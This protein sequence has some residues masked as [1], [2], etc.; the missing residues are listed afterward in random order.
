MSIVKFPDP[1]LLTPTAPFDFSNPP[2]DPHNLVQDMLKTMVDNNG[3]GLSANQVGLPYKV[4]VMRGVDFNY[5]CFNPKIV[6]YG[7]QQ[8]LMEE[9]CLSYPGLIIKIKRPTEVRLR[10]QTASGGIDTKTFNG[11]TA[12]IVQHEMDHLDGV[13]FYNRATRFHR[14]Q[15]M[16]RRGKFK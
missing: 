16:R 11:L 8:L 10:F 2:V 3:V 9:G 13:A 6:S 12:R 14:D 4:F 7:D 5:A 15:A 1:I